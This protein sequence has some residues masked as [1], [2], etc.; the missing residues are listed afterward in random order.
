[1]K[2]IFSLFRNYIYLSFFLILFSCFSKSELISNSKIVLIISGEGNNKIL[3]EDFY[4]NPSEVYVNGVLKSECSKTCEMEKV[5]NNITIKFN[6]EINTFENMFKGLDKI[7]EI[8][9]SNFDCSKVTNMNSTFYNCFNLTQIFFGN[10][11]TS[12]VNT[13]ENLF[14]NCFKLK[15]IDLSSFN[16]SSVTNMREMFRHCET[17][18]KI[19]VSNFNTS[20]VE[21]MH[22]LFAYCYKLITVDLS[23]FDTSKVKIMKGI[24]YY[25]INLRYLDLQSFT[26][27]S[28]TNINY[29]I[30]CYSLIYLNLRNFKINE[31]NNNREIYDNNWYIP[32]DLKICIEDNYTMHFLFGDRISNCSDDCFQENKIIDIEQK[33]CLI[34]YNESKNNFINR[35]NDFYEDENYISNTINIKN[36]DEIIIS[37]ILFPYNKE[38]DSTNLDISIKN[39]SE[40]ISFIRAKLMNEF[41]KIDIENFTDLTYNEGNI[42]YTITTTLNEKNKINDNKSRINFGDCEIKLKEKNNISKNDSLFIIKIDVFN[43]YFKFP[44][45]EY[46]LY[47][48]FSK[49]NITKLDLSICKDI[50]INLSIPVNISKDEIQKYNDSSELYNDIC[51]TLTSENGCDKTIKDRQKEYKDNNM[52]LCEEE[53][54]FID[55]DY[56]INKAICSCFTKIK[57]PFIPEISVDKNKLFNNFKNINNIGNF[58]ML[59]CINLF[60]DKSNF[61]KNTSNYMTIILFIISIISIFIFIFYDNDNKNNFIKENNKNNI[62]ETNGLKIGKNENILKEGQINNNM[63]NIQ[64]NLRNNTNMK[65]FLIKNKKYVYKKRKSIKNIIII[66]ENNSENYNSKYLFKS[67]LDLDVQNELYNDMELNSLSYME[68]LKK[69]NRSFCQYYLSLLKIKHLI[70]FTFFRRK[71]FNSQAIKI[72]IFFFIYA[73]N[74]TVSA[75]FYSDTTMHIIYQRKGSFDFTYQLP[76]MIYSLLI[77][78]LLKNILNVLG[79]YE[80]NILEIKKISD[81]KIIQ[82]KLYK[83]KCKIIIFFILTYILLFFFW[84]YLGCFCAVYKNTQIHLFINVLLSFAFSF[85]TPFI[86]CLIP[87]IFRIISLNKNKN[88]RYLL[89]K[90][91]KLLQM[92]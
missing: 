57:L 36:T 64:L 43:D 52:S 25:S 61:F 3:N 24:F 86:K 53:C 14:S 62:N 8:D 19:D 30:C 21:D 92:L 68:A 39:N 47:Y 42:I 72:Y 71:D 38:V 66:K 90:F 2:I 32:T 20:K 49:S 56:T 78:S 22:D 89:Y 65:N 1:M 80:D 15:S 55:Y 11:N 75:M 35:S 17:I 48:P 41:D 79:L 51:S 59:E 9:L 84:I 60:F 6:D 46:E 54:E 70:I 16:T 40:I 13:M 73:I 34:S 7:I 88:N 76:Q 69:D 91:S 31:N 67:K 44:K 28:I 45:I 77:S 10:I 33:K 29:M 5:I 26:A 58:K 63:K 81:E 82:K 85:V 27:S 83:I 12:S 50:K 87:G 37:S 23:H 4:K 18:D 74:H